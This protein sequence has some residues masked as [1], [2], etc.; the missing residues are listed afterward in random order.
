MRAKWLI[1]AGA[2]VLLAGCG[3]D[4]ERVNELRPPAPI[5][6][7]A[8][9]DDDKVLVTPKRFGAGPVVLIVSNQSSKPQEVTFETNELAGESGGIQVTSR[10]IGPSSTG[11]VQVSPKPGTYR[12]RVASSAIE[13]AEVRV[14][15]RR[16]SAQD[17]LLLP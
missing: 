7:T 5:N 12:I 3:G 15:P 14:G 13:P 16:D 4:D 2:A 8:A 9:V 1:A 11:T 10:P 17:E 6:V